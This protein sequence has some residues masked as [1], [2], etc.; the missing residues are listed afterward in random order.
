MGVMSHEVRKHVP[1]VQRQVA[2]DVPPRGRYLASRREPELEQ[3]RDALAAAPQRG[4][5]LAARDIAMVHPGRR[6]QPVLAAQGPDPSAPRVVQ[7]GRDHAD[8]A[9]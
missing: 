6:P 1:D 4:T 5:E 3:L 8:G 7:V 9:R 2:P